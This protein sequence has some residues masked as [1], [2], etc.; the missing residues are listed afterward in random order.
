M[1]TLPIDK[2]EASLS[3]SENCANCSK[4]LRYFSQKDYLQISFYVI[5]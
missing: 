2:T 3:D 4:K 1:A 5:K